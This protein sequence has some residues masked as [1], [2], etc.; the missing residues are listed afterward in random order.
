MAK[1]EKVNDGYWVFDCPGC[2]CLHS[3]QVPP[4]TFNGDLEKPTVSPSI[5]VNP[6]GD[7]SAL[8]CHSFVKDG[9]IQFLGDCD[10]DLKGQTVEIPD[11]TSMK[12]VLNR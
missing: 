11:W 1:V 2:K 4:W 6:N 5:L 3:I 9:M 10:H 12:E 8:R 7:S